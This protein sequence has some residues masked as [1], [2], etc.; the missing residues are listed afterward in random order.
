MFQ[1]RR[2]NQI[3]LF[4]SAVV[5]ACLAWLTQSNP[6]QAHGP[7]SFAFSE[8]IQH[9]KNNDKVRELSLKFNRSVGV[10]IWSGGCAVC[11]LG[12]RGG[13]PRNVYGNAINVLL[14]YT[15]YNT[16]GRISEAGRRV[17]DIPANP[18][19]PESPTFGELMEQGQ[20]PVPIFSRE[21][22]QV[23][24]KG[25]DPAS[26]Q[27]TVEEARKRVKQVQ[28]ESRFGIL[29]LSKTYEISPE[30]A[31]ELAEFRGEC[32]M[33]G[34]RSLTPEV[35]EALAK[36]KAANVWLH[37][38]SSL[39]PEAAEAVA[40]VPGHLVLTGLT[41]LNSVP[42]AEKLAKRPGALSLPYVKQITPAIARAL[43]THEGSLTLGGLTNV[44]PEVQNILAEATGPVH[45]P[46]LRSLDSLALTKKLAGTWRLF[47]PDL[48]RLTIE[49]AEQFANSK[50]QKFLSAAAMTPEVAELF[51][52]SKSPTSISLFGNGP[53]SDAAFATLLKVPYATLE[54]RDVE[55]PTPEQIKI[56][57]EAKRPMFFPQLKKLDAVLLAKTLL[58]LQVFPSVTSISP[59]VA[60]ALGKLP[61]GTR[62]RPDGKVETIPSG[63]LSFPSLEE[64]SPETAR[65]LL[66]KRWI[67]LSFPAVQDYSVETIR[68]L[69]RQTP[70]LT[71]GLTSLPPELA[72]AYTETE[73]TGDPR[74]NGGGLTL[75][76]L[77]DLSPE[78]ARILV[79]GMN[80]GVEMQGKIRITKT[81]AL[82]IGGRFGSA[83]S[84]LKLSPELTA[85]LGKYEGN[86]A[87]GGI[88]ELSPNSAA[89]LAKFPGPYLFLSGPGTERFAPETAAALARIPGRVVL[90]GLKVIDSVP[91]CD[92]NT[93]DM[94]W[95]WNRVEIV[96]PESIP[97]LIQFKQWFNLDGL[98]VLDS[99]A[100]AKRLIESPLTGGRNLHALQR[101]TPEAAEVLATADKPL[102]LGLSVL[103]DVAVARALARSKVKIT[104][105]RLKAVTPEVL[106]ILKDASGIETPAPESL[107]L[108]SVGAGKK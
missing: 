90:E 95:Y 65:L 47:L 30:V 52:Q 15:D 43:A 14:S 76:Y 84:G 103:D 61:E 87:I 2:G 44:T 39:I 7:F 97:A 6:T 60:D 101:I 73:A 13:T 16:P 1:L 11:H 32:L 105:Q 5:V 37:S 59:E 89:P 63:S 40:K 22:P 83:P 20:L 100:L 33:L 23:R 28:A 64:L 72:A 58:G 9:V 93:R 107:Y 56:M 79:K 24:R 106:A 26:E 82:Y 29:Q 104:L 81:P 91:L 77:S 92:K 31:T 46:G 62:K 50:G 21:V 41:E 42:L 25:L 18:S 36:S 70:S 74:G 54:M 86:L 27:I 19:M 108:L 55:T 53:I 80:R 48:D 99:P 67:S 69:A 57:A 71:L 66:Q 88:R 4:R 75:P 45:L 35:A 51:A 3:S 94:T 49:Q 96:A 98:T 10:D 85:E 102:R 34:I 38:L 12:G 78:A 8:Q 68:A 17:R